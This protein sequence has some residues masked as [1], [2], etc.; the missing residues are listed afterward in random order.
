MRNVS[1]RRSLQGREL[2]VSRLKLCVI[3]RR[4]D[5]AEHGA[6]FLGVDAVGFHHGANHRVGQR[7]VDR[8]FLAIMR[9][10]K[11]ILAIVFHVTS[12]F[13]I[14]GCSAARRSCFAVRAAGRNRQWLSA[15]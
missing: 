8:E 7:A 5:V 6:Q 2:R 1:R 10:V 13:L 4:D 15:G 11:V 12:F 14:V 9:L 3:E